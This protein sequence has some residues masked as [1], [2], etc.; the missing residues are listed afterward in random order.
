MILRAP[1]LTALSMM[2]ALRLMSMT[3]RAAAKA[4]FPRS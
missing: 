1:P 4:I 2:S 3:T